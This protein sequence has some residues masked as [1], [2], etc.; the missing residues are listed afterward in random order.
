MIGGMLSSQIGAG[1]IGG[2][3]AGFLAGY[4]IVLLKKWIKLPKTM[5]GL[6][7]VLIL[8]LLSSLI[9]GL[10]MIYVIGTPA[11]AMNTGISNWLDNLQEG[12]AIILGL[13]IGLMMA[14]DMGGPIN[15]AAYTFGVGTIAA[16]Q[17]SSVM[18]AVMAA[19]MTPPLGIGIATLL[20]KN[21]F[22]KQEKE[23]EKQHWFWDYH[24]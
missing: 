18:A 20:Y 16:G 14:F 4:T 15:K 3:I 11:A 7:P 13:V 6:M 21:K 8:P 2:I 17:S 10:L 9:V 5:E 23:A 12:S 1:F 24:S 22:T 19:G